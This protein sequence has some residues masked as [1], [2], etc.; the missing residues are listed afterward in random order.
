MCGICHISSYTEQA[1]SH[2]QTQLSPKWVT[3]EVG[4]RVEKDF[5]MSAGAGKCCGK[6]QEDNMKM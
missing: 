1:C 5:R 6:G 3:E 2:K 4:G